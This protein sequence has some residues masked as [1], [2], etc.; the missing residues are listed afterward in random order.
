MVSLSIEVILGLLNDYFRQVFSGLAVYLVMAGNQLVSLLISTVIFA[1]I[2]KV[3][4]DANIRW[5]NVWI[6]AAV[7][8]VLFVIGKYG[9]NIYLQ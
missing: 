8:A 9:I 3:L 6:G 4:P 5:P 1:A 7:T 2:F